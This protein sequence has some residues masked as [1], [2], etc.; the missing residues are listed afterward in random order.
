MDDSHW[1]KTQINA[2]DWSKY[3]AFTPCTTGSTE[4]AS[5]QDCGSPEPP[6]GQFTP[7]ACASQVSVRLI[8]MIRCAVVLLFSTRLLI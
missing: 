8:N 3:R 1:L 6:I 5:I 2:D 7:M 4:I